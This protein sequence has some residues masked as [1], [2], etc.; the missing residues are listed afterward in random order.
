MEVQL[1]SGAAMD[2]FDAFQIA[3]CHIAE[4]DYSGALPLLE[5][6]AALMAGDADFDA[7]LASCRAKCA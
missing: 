3:T 1:T 4:G 2:P 6:A 7:L 5:V